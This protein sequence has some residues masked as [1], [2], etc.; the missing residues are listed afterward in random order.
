[1]KSK[2][3]RF[4]IH[5]III[6]Q[7][8]TLQIVYK[9]LLTR[10]DKTRSMPIGCVWARKTLGAPNFSG[11]DNVHCGKEITLDLEIFRGIGKQWK[12]YSEFQILLWTAG[13]LKYESIVYL[14][15][16][17]KTKCHELWN[18]WLTTSI[19]TGQRFIQGPSNICD[20]IFRRNS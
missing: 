14:S 11:E 20:G 7:Y 6:S 2:V 1:M 3:V 12:G 10:L 19:R 8:E 18:I 5:N 9:L 16:D 17:V 13:H 15:D 4:A